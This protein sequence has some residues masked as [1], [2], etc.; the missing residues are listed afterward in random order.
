MIEETNERMNSK[1]IVIDIEDGDANVYED[2]TYC[3]IILN[4]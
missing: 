2:N 1:K 3:S 4:E